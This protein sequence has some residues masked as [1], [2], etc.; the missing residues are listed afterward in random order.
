MTINGILCAVYLWKLTTNL[1]VYQNLIKLIGY[2]MSLIVVWD[3]EYKTVA[4]NDRW[5]DFKEAKN[6]K[7]GFQRSCLIFQVMQQIG[8]M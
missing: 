4:K 7:K 6:E 2:E 8:L 5:F 1:C 3:A